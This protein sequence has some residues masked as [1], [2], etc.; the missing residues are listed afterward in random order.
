MPEQLKEISLFTAQGLADASARYLEA[1]EWPQKASVAFERQPEMWA[2]RDRSMVY[3]AVSSLSLEIQRYNG[4]LP[5][6]AAEAYDFN[7]K[8]STDEAFVDRARYILARAEI[9]GFIAPWMVGIQS[10]ERVVF[11]PQKRSM[12]PNRFLPSV[13]VNSLKGEL[14]KMRRNTLRF[15]TQTITTEHS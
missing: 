1:L 5:F 9:E 14:D 4:D 7:A 11:S 8:L 10:L 6:A 2:R 12:L 13:S 15:Y 3:P